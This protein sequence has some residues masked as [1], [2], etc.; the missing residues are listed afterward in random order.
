[1]PP[2]Q[3]IDTVD[4]YY[5]ENRQR[6]LSLRFLTWFVLKENIQTDTHDSIEDALSALKLYKVHLQLEEE[7]SFDSKLEE[8]YREGRQYVRLPVRNFRRCDPYHF[9]FLQNFKPPA[10]PGAQTS[11]PTPGSG[12]ASP[13]PHAQLGIS[14]GGFLPQVAQFGG[15]HFPLNALGTPPFFPL[16]P[17][18]GMGPNHHP[19]RGF[20]QPNW[21]NG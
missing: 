16:Q 19:H 1:M 7:G 21:R 3:V 6:R 14:R 5:L 12:T 18:N 10:V 8:V 2:E 20:M 11:T 9:P 15:G 4:L 13:M 17:G